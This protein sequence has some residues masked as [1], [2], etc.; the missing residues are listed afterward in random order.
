MR[1]TALATALTAATG[2]VYA[3]TAEAAS[4]C[5]FPT[6]KRQMYAN[7]TFSGTPK[8]TDCDAKVSEN[9]GTAAPAR[10][11]PKDN[12]AVR[13]TLTRDFGSGGPF[14]LTATARDGVRVYVDG[15]REVNIWKN[16]SSTQWK[17]VAVTI[18]SGKHTLRVDYVNWTGAA[19]ITF[20]Y[21]PRTYA[22]ASPDL[23]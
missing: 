18:P 9:W 6:F 4:T 23:D 17:T 12:F 19:D 3:L 20:T 16:V 22:A 11:L 8:K 1:T 21:A 5:V 10:T 14:T 2:T 13:W 15:E 7:T